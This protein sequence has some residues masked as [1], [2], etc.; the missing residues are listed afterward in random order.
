MGGIHQGGDLFGGLQT[1][2]GS[3]RGPVINSA[4]GAVRGP[5]T[6]WGAGAIEKERLNQA[7]RSSDYHT[8]GPYV[9]AQKYPV[10]YVQGG[11]KRVDTQGTTFNAQYPPGQ[12]QGG[13]GFGD[14]NGY[15]NNKNNNN[16]NYHNKHNNNDHTG[17]S[18]N[19]RPD[20][21]Y[22]RDAQE[23]GQE[24]VDRGVERERWNGGNDDVTNL[25]DDVRGAE[26]VLSQKIP[27]KSDD[28]NK[29]G[30]QGK[31]GGDGDRGRKRGRE[32]VIVGGGG[33]SGERAGGGTSPM[34]W[35]MTRTAN[36]PNHNNNDSQ[37]NS[38]N[39]N[40][41]NQD[42]DNKNRIRKRGSSRSVSRSRSRS[43][44]RSTWKVILTSSSPE[45]S[46]RNLSPS[47][48]PSEENK[49]GRK[50]RKEEKKVTK[51]KGKKAGRA[52]K[53]K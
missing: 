37:N 6:G 38:D 29:E 25:D 10:P 2:R 50:K 17:F 15:Q 24:S 35:S 41:N 20:Q 33:G 49:V 18:R 22:N 1:S 7:S 47:P 19:D 4:V 8:S 28:E 26:N 39:H 44:S 27:R 36:L 14:R 48:T 51:E 13:K 45:H 53:A 42:D 31:S 34:G 23:H 46:S 43:K 52:T 9:Q 40:N 32:G 3:G 21:G 12:G 11:N 5:N 30:L 16:N